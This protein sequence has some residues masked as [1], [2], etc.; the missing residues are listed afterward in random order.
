MYLEILFI[1]PHYFKKLCFLVYFPLYVTSPF[2]LSSNPFLM[3]AEVLSD[4]YWLTILS[5]IGI[6]LSHLREGNI[7]DTKNRTKILVR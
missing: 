5:N 4:G 7:K 3:A 6:V 2:S 1:F